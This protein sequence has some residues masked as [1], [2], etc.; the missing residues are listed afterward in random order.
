M[1]TLKATQV[2]AL[3]IWFNL[4]WAGGVYGP[5][6]MS[7]ICGVI[8]LVLAFSFDASISLI[9]LLTLLGLTM[10]GTL[11]YLG[12]Y[13]FEHGL[14]PHWLY[15]LW[16]GFATYLVILRQK[17]DQI[18]QLGFVLV[19]SLFAPICYWVGLQTGKLQWPY[20][21]YTTYMLSAMGW[22]VYSAVIHLVLT[23]RSP[24]STILEKNNAS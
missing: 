16:F 4:A 13:R 20:G 19:M 14:M 21:T 10:D 2:L 24:V 3:S 15:G 11:A 1:D 22:L 17:L 8:W 12:F 18:S 6:W 7:M 23:W 5:E 9:A